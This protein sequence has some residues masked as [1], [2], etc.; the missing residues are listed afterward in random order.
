MSRHRAGSRLG[1]AGST[2]LTV[3]GIGGETVGPAPGAGPECCRRICVPCAGH[4][5][6]ITATP[7]SAPGRRRLAST[8][9]GA[10]TSGA[11]AAGAGRGRVGSQRDVQE[12]AVPIVIHCPFRRAT[13]GSDL[14]D[15]AL[16]PLAQRRLL[17][18]DTAWPWAEAITTAS[19]HPDPP[20]PTTQAPERR[21]PQEDRRSS[22]P[23]LRSTQ[24][25]STTRLQDRF[26]I[27]AKNR[28]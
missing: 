8:R 18:I 28:G 22:L 17:K 3:P 20:P 2:R 5:S 9:P 19:P 27:M 14:V 15:A 26:T 1:G 23:P 12:P 11:P 16:C 6:R 25:T 21:P 13:N 4:C 7:R 10:N 24:A